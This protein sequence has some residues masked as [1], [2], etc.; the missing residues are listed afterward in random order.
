VAG[1]LPAADKQ[2]LDYITVISLVDLNALVPNTRTIS[3]G[4]GLTGGGDL[5]ANRSFAVS[6]HADGS[7]SVSG[8]GVQVG[9]LAT[10]AQHGTRGGGSIH[11]AATTSVAGFMSAADKTKLDFVTV[12]EAVTLAARYYGNIS[13]VGNAT[14]TTIGVAGT[15]VKIAGTYTSGALT[16]GIN[17]D[18]NGRLT[19]T[20]ATTRDFLLCVSCAISSANVN[21]SLRIYVAK[22][23]TVIADSAQGLELS[24]ANKQIGAT[25]N[26]I[27]SLATND[28]VEVFVS[29]DTAANNVTS[30]SVHVALVAL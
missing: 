18:T 27:V 30:V 28:Y 29:N 20:G 22:N 21:Q 3:A 13:M 12:S 2:K 15:P 19:Y 6:P 24:T 7:I 5:S 1:F 23:G 26:Y 16:T 8:S 10:D 25:T 9:I 17:H 11:A 14:A 4:N